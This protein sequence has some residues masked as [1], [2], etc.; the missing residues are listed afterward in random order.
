[1][2]GQGGMR[3]EW[4]TAPMAISE[5]RESHIPSCLQL[6]VCVRCWGL[7]V[8]TNATFEVYC[9]A[10]TRTHGGMDE[11]KEEGEERMLML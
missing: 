10:D 4:G 7:G 1:M 8:D 5:S 9:C 6:M 11:T 2:L 3:V